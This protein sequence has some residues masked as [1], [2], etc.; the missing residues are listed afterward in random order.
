[1]QTPH[2]TPPQVLSKP[3][4]VARNQVEHTNTERRVLGYVR[5]PFIV[6][7]HYA[8]QT[9]HKLYFVLE[10]C[11]GGELFTHIGRNK[12]LTEKHTRFYTAEIASALG[13]LHSLGVLYRDLKPENILLDAKGHIKLADFGLSKE[14]VHRSF[15][16]TNSFCGT[17][18]YIAPE[19]IEGGDISKGG[20][21]GTAVDWWSLGM[22][23]Y[24]MLTGLPPWCV[25]APY[26]QRPRTAP[27]RCRAHEVLSAHASPLAAPLP[28]LS[29][30]CHHATLLSRRT[31][32]RPSS[33]SVRPPG[34][35]LI[36]RSSFNRFAPRASPSLP[37]SLRSRER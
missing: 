2:T 12:R 34:T 8:F 16:V 9:R 27:L 17:P 21:H 28:R 25:A 35:R 4:I 29:P 7:L 26:R 13:H 6:A 24:E 18:E 37:T 22:V 10:Y 23:V 19:V 1:M 31:P 33:A 32:L 15:G 11:P 36:A 5:H 3:Y 20:G 14:D 30:S